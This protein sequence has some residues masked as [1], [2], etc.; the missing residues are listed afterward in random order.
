MGGAGQRANACFAATM[1]A[2][3]IEMPAHAAPTAPAAHD[4]QVDALRVWRRRAAVLRIALL[5]VWA[6]ASFGLT[7]WASELSALAGGPAVY[8]LLAQGSVL[9]FMAVVVVYAWVMNRWAR[10]AGQEFDGG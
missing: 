5:L 1:A 3:P 2:M 6:A 7:W 10:E 9:V 8:G 4:P